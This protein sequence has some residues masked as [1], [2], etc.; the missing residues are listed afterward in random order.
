MRPDL[1]ENGE[2]L[3]ITANMFADKQENGVTLIPPELG[4]GYIKGFV[5]NSKLRLIVRDYELKQNWMLDRGFGKEAVNLVRIAFHNVYRSKSEL[6]INIRQPDGS[7]KPLPSVQI[8]T[9]GL[10]YELLPANKKVNSIVIT[11]EAGYLKELLKPTTENAL[12]KII[13]SGDK[14]LL[15]EEVISPKIHEVASEII[16]ADPDKELQKFYYKIKAEEMMYL[17]F[18]ALLKRGETNYQTLNIADVRKIYE[19]K[20]SIVS[21]IYTPPVFTELVRLS[22]MSETKLKRL[23]KQIFGESIYNYYQIYRMNEA[24]YLMKDEGL[25][26]SEAG[27]RLGFSNLGHFSRLF[28][29][30]IG[31]KPKK[32]SAAGL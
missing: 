4:T 24:A 32:Y 6:K 13:T 10:N 8:V 28:E 11:V 3:P 29:T 15:F 19:V 1:T 25:S 9:T 2:I 12:L 26:V 23:F 21:D 5:I 31:V 18:A 27:Y 7:K 30:H 14:S 20:D 22:G 16:K 17:L